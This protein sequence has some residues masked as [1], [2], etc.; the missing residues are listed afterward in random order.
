TNIGKGEW[1]KKKKRIREKLETIA[2]DLIKVQATREQNTGFKYSKDSEFQKLFEDDFEFDETVD[3][4]KAIM[5][6]K[7]DME[8][9]KIIDRLICG[10]V[11]YGKT[12]I[13]MRIAFKTVFDNKQVA[14]L[15][16]TTIL[17]RQHYYNFKERF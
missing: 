2:L 5:E 16:P 3:Q 8:E 17:T 7:K 9:G 11:G 4:L 10:D 13:A 15:A 14:Y 6:I 1:D 12:E